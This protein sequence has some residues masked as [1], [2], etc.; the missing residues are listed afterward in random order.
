ME[1]IENPITDDPI[2]DDQPAADPVPVVR[3]PARIVTAAMVSALGLRNG[4]TAAQI[5]AAIR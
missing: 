3:A 1:N 4:M 2:I 5:D